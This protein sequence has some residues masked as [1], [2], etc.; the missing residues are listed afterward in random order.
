MMDDDRFSHIATEDCD[1]L[2]IASSPLSCSLAEN[3][4]QGIQWN[5]RTIVW[6]LFGGD[7][8]LV[9]EQLTS[10]LFKT[11]YSISLWH[12]GLS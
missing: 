9:F 11:K 1:V 10:E 12:E 8:E 4:D 6:L 2:Q 5:K 7:N 3:P